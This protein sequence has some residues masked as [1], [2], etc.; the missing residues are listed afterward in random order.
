MHKAIDLGRKPGNDL[1]I[2]LS[3]G[4]GDKVYYPDLHIADVDDPRLL[5]MP[6]KGEATI[7]FKV[8]HRSHSEHERNGKKERRCSVTIEVQKI[9]F[10]D[11]PKTHKNN[12]GYGDDARKSFADY[13]KDR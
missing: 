10:Q 4:D 13:F 7:K 12:Q 9:D 1:P 8:V 5:E 3:I 2:P 11:N 6:D